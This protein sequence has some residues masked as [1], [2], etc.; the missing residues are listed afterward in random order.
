[1]KLLFFK[2]VYF[3]TKKWEKSY[4]EKKALEIT[5]TPVANLIN[6][7]LAV[8]IWLIGFTKGG[9]IVGLKNLLTMSAYNF[10]FLQK[11]MKC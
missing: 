7:Y 11:Y 1:M 10:F 2:L 6:F 8:V 4:A 9:M 3:C 5:K